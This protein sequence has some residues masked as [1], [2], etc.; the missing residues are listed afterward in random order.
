M[1]TKVPKCRWVQQPCHLGADT[2]V[3]Y[4]AAGGDAKALGHA[5]SRSGADYDGRGLVHFYSPPVHLASAYGHL[6]CL[7]LLLGRGARADADVDQRGGRSPLHLAALMGH[8][9]VVESLLDAGCDVNARD[10]CGG[11]PA[12]HAAA[13][14]GH[15]AVVEALLRRGA[16]ARLRAGHSGELAL[17]AA[18]RGNHAR[19]VE[20]LVAHEA[21][22]KGEKELP[23]V[24]ANLTQ[25]MRKG[26][27]FTRPHQHAYSSGSRACAA[28]IEAVVR[29]CQAA[30]YPNGPGTGK[31]AWARE[32]D[33]TPA[34]PELRKPEKLEAPEVDQTARAKR[35]DATVVLMD[36]KPRW[37]SETSNDAFGQARCR[38]CDP[39]AKDARGRRCNTTHSSEQHAAWTDMSR[40]EARK[41]RIRQKRDKVQGRLAPGEVPWK[42]W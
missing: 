2:A 19:V 14:A 24:I 9:A 42:A 6:E 40:A 5:L 35:D 7:E 15:L 11:T 17:H 22:G 3:H 32:L 21:E 12:L 10:G 8:A 41:A 38:L 37:K 31:R 30:I 16:D 20:A 23:G 27:L 25:P 4:H 18:A 39:V 13:F 26:S 1:E 34:A 29:D 36:T 28:P 33:S